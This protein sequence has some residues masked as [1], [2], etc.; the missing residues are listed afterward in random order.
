M[1]KATIVTGANGQ[2]GRAI[3]NKL[4]SLKK[5]VIAVDLNFDGFEENGNVSPYHL[6]IS[7]EAQ[8]KNFFDS[9]SSNFDLVGLVNNAGVAVFTPF[10]ERSIDELRYVFDI[11]IVGSILMARGFMRR[12]QDLDGYRSVVNIASIYGAVAPDLTIYGD[13]PRMSSEIY[14]I[15]KAGIINFTQYLASYYRNSSVVFNC[16]SPGGVERNQG[17][18][19]KKLYANKV[20]LNRMAKDFEVAEV[21]AFLLS[22]AAS[23][24][25]GENIF[26]DG[27]FTKW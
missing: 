18:N 12:V 1:R 14:G 15:T 17:D 3:I 7:D 24:V 9:I 8:V 25:N 22:D 4:I 19:F 11:N 20:P 26:V 16:V 27:G 23:Y 21:I 5:E 2:L 6:D 10:E 13:T